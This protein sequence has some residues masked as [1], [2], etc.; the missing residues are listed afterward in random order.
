MKV[1]VVI[2]LLNLVASLLYDAI[3][4]RSLKLPASLE[5]LMLGALCVPAAI[6]LALLWLIA[7]GVNWARYVLAALVALVTVGY[8]AI[9]DNLLEFGEYTHYMYFALLSAAVQVACIAL[10]F[11]RS[12]APWF[13]R[14]PLVQN[15]A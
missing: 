9:G 7:K 11:S 14:R 5:L 13:R 2:Y 10:L 4:N 6:E 12:A 1:A 3:D 15:A 8:F